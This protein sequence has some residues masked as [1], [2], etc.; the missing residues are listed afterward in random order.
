MFIMII[1]AVAVVQQISHHRMENAFKLESYVDSAFMWR[2]EYVS[3]MLLSVR[4]TIN[5]HPIKSIAYL[6]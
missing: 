6:K 5:Y 4:K 2:M 3:L 1:H